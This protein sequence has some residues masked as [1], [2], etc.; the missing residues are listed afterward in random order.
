MAP[1][2]KEALCLSELGT[3]L[4][5]SGGEYAYLCAA[6]DSLGRPGDFVAFMTM[7][8]TILLADPMNAALQSLTFTSYALTPFYPTC[9]PPY[10][11][12]VLVAIAFARTNHMK[13]PFVS[14]DVTALGLTQAYFAA[15]MSMGGALF[16]PLA[17]IRLRYTMKDAPR[18]ITVPYFFILLNLALNMSIVAVNV[19]QSSDYVILI[20]LGAVLLAGT[21]VYVVFLV[22]RCV[23]PGV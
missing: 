16:T 12:T 19:W 7:W 8:G 11:V 1:D 6:A 13:A 3:L 23:L 18:P 9:Q 10:E 15:A 5:A 22:Q 4:P 21:M 20:V 17:Q 2:M 14:G